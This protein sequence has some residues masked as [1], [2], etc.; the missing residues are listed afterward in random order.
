MHGLCSKIKSFFHR[1]FSIAFLCQVYIQYA[2]HAKSVHFYNRS[3]RKFEIRKFFVF[4]VTPSQWNICKENVVFSI[5]CVCEKCV[6]IAISMLKTHD[7]RYIFAKMSQNSNGIFHGNNWICI[8]TTSSAFFCVAKHFS[9]STPHS[10]K[11]LIISKYSI[12]ISHQILCT[13]ST[14]LLTD[15]ERNAFNQRIV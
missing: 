8:Y 14:K 9:L 12:Y 10:K 2:Y 3:V 7:R 6:C 1:S 11:C 5:V 13:N 15:G 4:I